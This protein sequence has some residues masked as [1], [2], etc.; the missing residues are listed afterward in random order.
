M[1]KTFKYRLKPNKSDLKKLLNTLE[2]CRTVYNKTLEIRKISWESEKKSISY[3]EIAS[4]L[5][6]WKEQ[7]PELKTVHSQVL[8]DAMIRVD[9][10][11]KAFFKRVKSGDKPGYP[12]FK[13]KNRYTAGFNFS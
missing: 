6:P 3:F 7:F 2:I 5:S 9:L 4:N 1:L 12:R 8:Q 11:F 10:A 13:A